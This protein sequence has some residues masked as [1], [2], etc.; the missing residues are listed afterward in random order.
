VN[1][2]TALMLVVAL[3]SGRQSGSNPWWAHARFA[4]TETA[5]ESIPVAKL[6]RSW[7]R[8]TALA[9][10][11]MPAAATTP[12][13]TVEENGGAFSLLVD[14]D[15][16]GRQERALVGV[17]ESRSGATGRFLLI[18]NRNSGGTWT[19]RALFK[20]EGSPGFSVLFLSE[21]RIKWATCLE[22]DTYCELIVRKRRALKLKCD[23]CCPD[24]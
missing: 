22:C 4:S 24:S 11:L 21:G 2:V 10:S 3:L 6:D 1:V 8:A 16:D 15:G 14:L 7:V 19:K 17:Y 13:E 5:I 20:D 9:P 18:L 23:S 12:D